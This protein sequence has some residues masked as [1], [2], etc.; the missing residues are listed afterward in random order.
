MSG[1]WT[2]GPW[3]V[4]PY[5]LHE[6]KVDLHGIWSRSLGSPI[7]VAR[8]CFYPATEANARLIAAAPELADALRELV[9]A[10]KKPAEEKW[11]NPLKGQ[12]WDKY[13]RLVAAIVRAEELLSR[14]EDR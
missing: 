2:K 12:V 14:K 1:A 11:T 7:L 4:Q 8:T 3:F 9:E 5:P 10:A 6:A 13:P